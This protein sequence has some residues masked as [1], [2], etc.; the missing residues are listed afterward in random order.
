[1]GALFG[2]AGPP[3]TSKRALKSITES[4][5]TEISQT[6]YKGVRYGTENIMSRDLARTILDT[7]D[8]DITMKTYWIT[9]PEDDHLNIDAG[10]V[11]EEGFFRAYSY[12][13]EINSPVELSTQYKL[14]GYASTLEQAI[15]DV[16]EMYYKEV[17]QRKQT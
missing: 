12:V 6:I 4:F 14:I 2:K 9:V 10:L 8:K 1:M 16:I 11:I 15:D 13:D 17:E 3:T 7:M 5:F